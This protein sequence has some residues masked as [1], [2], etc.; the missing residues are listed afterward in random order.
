MI[1]AVK[2]VLASHATE[3]PIPKKASTDEAT[4]V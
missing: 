4:I 3:N 1:L 2:L